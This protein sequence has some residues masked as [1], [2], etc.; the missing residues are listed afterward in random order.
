MTRKFY[1]AFVD[2][3]YRIID[4]IGKKLYIYVNCFP[5]YVIL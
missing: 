2:S 3:G 1:T 4:R 5:K